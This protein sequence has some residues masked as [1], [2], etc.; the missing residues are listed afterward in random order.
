MIANL[1]HFYDA[2]GNNLVLVVGADDQENDWLGEA[3]AEHAAISKAPLARGLKKIN[4]E[5]ASVPMRERIYREGGILS[6]TSRILIVDLL[7]DMIDPEK[8]TGVIILHAEKVLATSLEA[9]IARV[10]R[11]KKQKWLLESFLR[12]TRTI[13]HRICPAS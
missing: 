11:Q 9:F 6:V 5:K 12:C 13:H 1:L 2:A 8:I 4:T 3:L 7:L 10:Y